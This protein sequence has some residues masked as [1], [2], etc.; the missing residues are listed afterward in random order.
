LRPLT[1]AVCGV[2]LLGGSAR[3]AE[4]ANIYPLAAKSLVLDVAVAGETLIAGADRGFILRSADSGETWVQQNSPVKVMLT[5]VRMADAQR[6]WAVGH[7]AVILATT[8]GG[9][10]W[11]VKF[12]DGALE[13]PL[14]DIWFESQTH[15]IAVGAYGLL[16]E[17][18]DGGETWHERRIADEEPHLYAITM[19]AD[20]L[21]FVVGE[22]GSV[23]KSIDHGINWTEMPTPY[24]GT[25]FGALALQQGGLLVYGLRGMLLRSDDAGRSWETL[26]TATESSLF[27]AV[28]RADRSVVVVGLSGT[29]LAS[30]DGRNFSGTVLPDR[31]ALSGAV[32]TPAGK[33]LLFGEKG[34]QAAPL[35]NPAR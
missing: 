5:A 11:N 24:K 17:T 30:P 2:L 21:L 22:S 16:L 27:G 7:D 32:E 9:V 4:P 15:G 20:G 28:Q 34:I 8:D 35:A 18:I 10:T 6:G 14:F 26:Q 1:L 19:T 12:Q 3:A 33:L 13:T 23:F 29:I 25:F 31:E